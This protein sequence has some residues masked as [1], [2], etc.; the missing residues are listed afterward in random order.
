MESDERGEISER[1]WWSKFKNNYI[2]QVV[3]KKVQNLSQ[4]SLYATKN[5]KGFTPTTRLRV[6]VTI[7][8]VTN[9]RRTETR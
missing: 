9:K 8:H 7:I 3:E 4:L 6:P 2:F 1:K 5:K